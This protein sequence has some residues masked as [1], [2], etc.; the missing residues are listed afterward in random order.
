MEIKKL[1]CAVAVLLGITSCN[2]QAQKKTESMEGKKIIVAFYPMNGNTKA[3]AEYIK[4]KTG[5]DIYEI[6]TSEVYSKDWNETVEIVGK[7]G[8]TYEPALIGDMP[9]VRK[10]DVVFIG[11]PCW[12]G[13]IANPV[14]SFLHEV[15]LSDKTIAPFMTHGTSGRKLQEMKKLCPNSTVLEGIG[16]YNRYQV[17]T[18]VN[19][20]ENLGDYKPEV[21]KWL[22]SI[23]F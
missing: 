8:K 11:T 19:S 3:V 20:V 16:I 18:K 10:Y 7:Q 12:W 21:D 1:I 14:R 23:G 4:S 15:D 13:T 17:E 6:K 9:N 5:A 2:G 22:K